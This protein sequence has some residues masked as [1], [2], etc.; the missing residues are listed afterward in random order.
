M[1]SGLGAGRPQGGGCRATAHRG[2]AQRGGARVKVGRRPPRKRRAAA[3]T[4]GTSGGTARA[5]GGVPGA[6]C[7][8]E[9]TPSPKDEGA[10]RRTGRRSRSRGPLRSF[11]QGEK[12]VLYGYARVSTDGQDTSAQAA[13]LRRAGVRRVV[14]ETASGA[15]E[16]VQLQRLLRSL[17]PGDVLVVWK[18]DRLARTLRGL[19]DV[20]D[21]VRSAGASLRSLTEPIDT[22]SPIG[23]AFFQ[24]LGVF[25]QLERSLIRERCHAGRL[26]ARAR[27]VRFGRPRS[28][29][30][31]AAA[32]MRAAGMSWVEIGQRIGRSPSTVRLA[33]T[34]PKRSQ[35]ATT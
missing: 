19:L 2:N 9:S 23:E 8:W 26:E 18:V 3:L 1:G 12:R 35:R 17:R 27:G 31:D 21:A 34:S 5:V 7:A 13:A 4:L 11:S 10:R 14:E 16:R 32:A 20:A 30:Y 28:F 29:D 6:R 33:L 24:L 25:A 22:G 15:G